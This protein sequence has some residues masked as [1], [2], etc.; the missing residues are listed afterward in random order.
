MDKFTYYNLGLERFKSDPLT[1]YF[2][3]ARY[4]FIWR[5]LQPGD[6]V[7]DLAC[8]DGM[9]SYVLARKG[10]RVTGM[11]I[12]PEF[13]E[14][15]RREFSAENLTFRAGSALEGEI[16]RDWDVI[17]LIGLFEYLD[18]EKS[19]LALSRIATALRP[20]GLAF[21]G[22]PNADSKIVATP[23]RLS[24]H[25]RELNAGRLRELLETQFSRVELFGQNDEYILPSIPEMSFFLM[26]RCQK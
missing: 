8:G 18:D 11:D 12:E 19:L 16:G 25:H 1:F 7:L 3:L 5:A 24:T 26:S 17:C 22:T 23:R 15:A 10:C 6:R 9:G 13:L 4:K 14:Y 21:V 20:G 2:R